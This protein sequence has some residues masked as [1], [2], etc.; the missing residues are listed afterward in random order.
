MFD[1]ILA[2][3]ALPVNPYRAKE[4]ECGNYFLDYRAAG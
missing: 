2:G 3:V 1:A 4:I